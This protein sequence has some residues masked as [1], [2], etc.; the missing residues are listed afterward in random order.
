MYNEAIGKKSH[1]K[2][3]QQ[4]RQQ[5]RHGLHPVQKTIISFP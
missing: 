5:M 2:T 1:E 4:M 3:F